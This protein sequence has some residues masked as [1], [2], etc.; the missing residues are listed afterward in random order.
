VLLRGVTVCPACRLRCYAG[1]RLNSRRSKRRA[2][3]VRGTSIVAP[4]ESF[5][6]NKYRHAYCW[7]PPVFRP[8]MPADGP[9]ISFL[10][11]RTRLDTKWL[12]YFV[13][14]FLFSHKRSGS[15]QRRNWCAGPTLPES[16]KRDGVR[17]FF[18]DGS[19]LG[20]DDLRSITLVGSRRLR[21]FSP[22]CVVGRASRVLWEASSVCAFPS[23]L[24]PPCVPLWPPYLLAFVGSLRSLRP[25]VWA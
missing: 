7:C 11:V 3:Q 9:I 5:S 6:K 4:D 17:Y 20:I 10:Y 8:G 21:P 12:T 19:L 25:R 15:P 1:R 22:S 14:G 24:R 23:C 13:L 16:M 2:R 18:S